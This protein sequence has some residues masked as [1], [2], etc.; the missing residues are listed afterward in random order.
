MIPNGP[1]AQSDPVL[2]LRAVTPSDTANLPNGDCR[3]LNCS[4]TGT[5]TVIAA[6]DTAAV[7]ITVVKGWNPIQVSRVL[8]SGSD[9]MTIVAGY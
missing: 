1:M 4:A 6:G 8:A 5:L 3:C 7:A 2:R 9:S